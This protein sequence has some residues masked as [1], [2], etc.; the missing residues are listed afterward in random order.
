MGYPRRLLND[1]EEIVLDLNPHWRIFL[2][3]GLLL[4]IALAALVAVPSLIE[5]AESWVTIVSAI[6]LG[7]GLI[8]FAY[9][10]ATWRTTHFVVTTDRVIYRSGI[11]SKAG[12]NIPL[13]RINNVAF[14]QTAIERLLRVGDLA[15]ESA[16]ETGRQT[17]EDVLNPSKVENRI[18]AEIERAAERDDTRAAR[19]GISV[20]DE[21]TKLEDLR[22][23]GVITVEEFEAQKAK[24]LS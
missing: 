7:L 20:A 5:D 11:I 24:L 3:P 17:F 1:N 18:Y 21:L 12:Q 22:R 10:Y 8:W 6:P 15:I 2:A 19:A 9:R 4:L 13:E 14:S 16:G 23:R